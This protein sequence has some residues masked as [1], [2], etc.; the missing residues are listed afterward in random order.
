MELHIILSTL[1]EAE[2]PADLKLRCIT[3]PVFASSFNVIV[4]LIVF[5]KHV[6]NK[7]MSFTNVPAEIK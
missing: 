1:T 5:V 2:V 3:Q 7:T 4:L 6:H